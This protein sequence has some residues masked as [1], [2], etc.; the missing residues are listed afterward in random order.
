MDPNIQGNLEHVKNYADIHAGTVGNLNPQAT[1]VTNNYY[2]PGS[3]HR[4]TYWFRRLRE[5]FAGDRRL[6]S[7]LDDLSRYRTRL[8][9]TIGLE[10]KL[11]DGGFRPADIA[12]AMRSK[13][14][15]SKQATRYQYF[16]SALRIDDYLFAKL[17]H[18]FDT[19]AMPL[20]TGGCPLPQ[21]RQAV[22]ERVITPVREEID[23]YGA[24]DSC[25]H[26]G[27]DDLYGMLY[28]LTG[29]CHIDW[30]DYDVHPRL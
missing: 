19:Y 26:Y 22:Y 24:E 4:L 30:A 27:E 21:V 7:K 3:E 8:P 1:S 10:A 12:S 16:E 20:I 17:C 11:R 6:S 29:K 25:L 13:Q 28:L 9:N 18:L 23:K 14:A 2:L 15:F 5:E